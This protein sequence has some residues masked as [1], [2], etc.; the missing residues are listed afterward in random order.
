MDTLMV[1]DPNVVEEYA[2]PMIQQSNSK[3]FRRRSVQQ[4]APFIH[5]S[6][7]DGCQDNDV[8]LPLHGDSRSR[9]VH[10]WVTCIV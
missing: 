7:N 10:R 1:S 4:R 5:L 9:R 3:R 8:D 2:D 6:D